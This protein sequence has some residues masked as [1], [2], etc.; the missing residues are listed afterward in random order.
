MYGIFEDGHH[1]DDDVDDHHA[2]QAQTVNDWQLIVVRSSV[3]ALPW[4]FSG[5]KKHSFKN[6]LLSLVRRV[7]LHAWGGMVHLT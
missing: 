2:A 4:R 6:C 5:R 7:I 1:G 3:K